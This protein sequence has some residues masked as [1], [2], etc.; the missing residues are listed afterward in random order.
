M[1]HHKISDVLEVEGEIIL[2]S[3]TTID[4]LKEEINRIM[5]HYESKGIHCF[6]EIPEGNTKEHLRT[7][8]KMLNFDVQ[9]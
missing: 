1:Q 2:Y 9:F 3:P 7:L 8:F 6:E 4:G 5:E